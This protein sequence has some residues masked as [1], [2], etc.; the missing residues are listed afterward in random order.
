MRSPCL[1]L[2]NLCI[3]S[4]WKLDITTQK[5]AD[6]LVGKNHPFYSFNTDGNPLATIHEVR[7]LG[8]HFLDDMNFKCHI[9]RIVSRANSIVNFILG[10]S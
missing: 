4:I 6:M 2:K 8:V 3:A 7:D 5:T 1:P 10:A 9:D